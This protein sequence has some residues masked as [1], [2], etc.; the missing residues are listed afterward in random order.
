M[1][2]LIDEYRVLGLND[3]DPGKLCWEY[4]LPFK[5]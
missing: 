4:D 5:G 1:L 3:D 2:E